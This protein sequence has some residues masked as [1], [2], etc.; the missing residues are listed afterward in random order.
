MEFSDKPRDKKQEAPEEQKIEEQ[1]IEEQKLE[2]QKPEEQKPEEQ[3]LKEK[4]PKKQK[5]EQELETVFIS[6]KGQPAFKKPDASGIIKKYITVQVNGKK[7]E[8]VCD[9]PA[10]ITPEQKEALSNYLAQSKGKSLIS[11]F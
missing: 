2:E 6:S 11:N 9:E 7:S 4:R 10:Q 3:K 5:E 8:V 1:K